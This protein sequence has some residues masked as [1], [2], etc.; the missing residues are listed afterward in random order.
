MI[1]C[2]PRR[3][4]HPSVVIGLD[5]EVVWIGHVA[6]MTEDRSHSGSEPRERGDSLITDEGVT[7]NELLPARPCRLAGHRSIRNGDGKPG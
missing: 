4:A 7:V 6:G 3:P 5:L 1:P 2:W